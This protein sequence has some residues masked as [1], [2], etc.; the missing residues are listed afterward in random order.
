M[1]YMH[2]CALCLTV[3]FLSPLRTNFWPQEG[4]ITPTENARPT[5]RQD[6]IRMEGALSGIVLTLPEFGQFIKF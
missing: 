4:G 5:Y 3:T 6:G 1:Q 2:I